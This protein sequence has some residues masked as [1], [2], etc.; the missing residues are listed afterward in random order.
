MKKEYIV[1]LILLAIALL[2]AYLLYTKGKKEG[3]VEQVSLPNDSA[4]GSTFTD[5]EKQQVRKLTNDLHYDMDGLNLLNRNTR[6][7]QELIG[8]SDKLFVAVYND[9]NSLYFK[10]ENIFG[11]PKNITLKE[12]ILTENFD[13]H[14]IFDQLKPL[15][16]ERFNKLNLI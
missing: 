5:A 11:N 13:W 8:L 4:V 10:E 6:P 9:F 14:N 3:S 2:A 1:A 12:W 15:M 7:Y 16:I